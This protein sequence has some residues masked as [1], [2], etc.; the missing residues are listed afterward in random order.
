MVRS[1]A[2]WVVRRRWRVIVTSLLLVVAATSGARL[3][4]FTAD[5]R[6]FFGEDNPELQAFEKLQNTYTK[7]DNVM[8]VLAPRDGDVFTRKTLAAVEWL[9]NEAWQIPYSNR[10]DS[11]TNFQHT[12]AEEDDL[13]V[14]DLVIGAEE[15]SDDDLERIRRVALSE[16]LLADRIVSGR[17]HVTAVNVVVQLPGDDAGKEVPEVVSHVRGLAERLEARFPDI[18]IHLAGIVMMNNAFPEASFQ[19][20]RTLVPAMFAVVILSLGLLLR[21]VSGTAVTVLVIVGSITG[22]MG[23]AGWLGIRLTPPSSAA[24]TMIL[25]LAVADCVHILATFLYEM[26]H[27]GKDKYRAMVESLRVNMQP[28]FLTSLTTA[29]GFL[30]MNF[31]DA[32]P[33]HD[34][35]NIVAMGVTIA[36]LLSVTLF[37]A[38]VVLLPVNVK[39]HPPGESHIMERVADWV[40]ANRRPLFWGVG[41]VMV[42]L[43]AFLPR[44]ELNDEFIK[45]F[46]ESFEFRRD[47]DFVTANLIGTY[48]FDYSLESGEPGG[49]SNPA[50]LKKVEE[51]AQWWRAQPETMHVNTLTD[52]L[53]R[54]NKNLHGDDPAWYRL[55]DDRELAAQY[56]LLYEMSLPYGLDLNN[57]INVDKSAT[58]MTVTFHSLSTSGVLEMEQRAQRWLE[59]N[60]PELSGSLVSSPTIMF[61]HIGARNIRSMLVGTTVALLLISAVLIVALRSWR[62]GL[63]S[64]IPNLAPAG[65]AFGAW[66]LL[67]GQ[68]GLSLSVVATMSL[69][70]VVD[71]TVHFLSKYLRARRE[72]GLDA[73]DSVRYAFATVGMALWIT[74]LVL[75]AGFGILAFSGFELNAGMGLLTAVTIGIALAAD[76]LFLPPLLMKIEEKRDE[77]RVTAGAAGTATP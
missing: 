75:I 36:F 42:V 14:E 9:T 25:T 22:A 2:E 58:R 11:L 72:K 39:A 4:Q 6:V 3:L 61:A 74:T 43:I 63:L 55:P 46:D 41:A 54:L 65:M 49:I 53:K 18:E 38:L 16:P 19:D 62:I 13:I 52:T 40:V 76:F 15:L 31:S 10:V 8:I 69:G 12:R 32:P 20:M 71:D 29:I 21:F 27:R 34:L 56:L 64:M 26:R 24:P 59:E 47:T 30:S 57:Q 35:G 23:L 70:I 67:V 7:N 37:P 68:V 60:A 17:G 77:T 66:G 44:N 28:I 73:V 45:Y 33:F 48:F 51:F 50:F 1:Y 5:Y